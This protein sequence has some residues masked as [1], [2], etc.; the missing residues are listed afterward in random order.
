MLEFST[1]DHLLYSPHPPASTL[2]QW[3]RESNHTSYQMITNIP[4]SDQLVP[5]LNIVNP[6]LWEFGHLT[7]FHEFWVHRHGWADEPS[8]LWDADFLFNSS[9]MAHQD[10]WS[11]P[12]PPLSNLLAYNQSVMEHTEQ[13]LSKPIDNKTK[14]FIQL[15]IFHQDMHN[16]AFAY[17]WQTLGR[18]LPFSRTF[19][20]YS[21]E[22]KTQPWIHFPKTT[23]QAGSMQYSG[24]IFDNEKWGYSIDLPPFSIAS[25]PVTNA[26]F[27]NFV[28]SQAN[29]SNS[30][31][32]TP[33]Y[34]KK[35]RD[36]WLERFFDRWIPL[37]PT[38]AVRHV[39]YQN[40]Q[41][42]CDYNKVRLPSEHEFSL[43]MSQKAMVWQPSNLWEWTSST[44]A[45]FPGFSTD[46][47]ADYSKP[48]FDGNYQ[49]LKGWSMFTP[50]RLRRNAFRN[51][52]QRNRSDHF[53]GFRTCL[54]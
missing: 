15:A 9:K 20:T 14:Y 2:E 22:D 38:S 41:R 7:W 10:R 33:S 49:V 43:L 30:K 52:Y 13:L 44:F 6:P 54:L 35:E 36:V 26:D 12:M 31:P 27:L 47:Y 16:E 8:L 11:A 18:P 24:F 4:L 51:F 34:W 5:R 53:C 37:N 17:M 28:E 23:I 1:D 42:F 3:L 46:P 48:W 45:P 32:I 39:S 29:V 40:A 19:H 25:K 21:L 50:E